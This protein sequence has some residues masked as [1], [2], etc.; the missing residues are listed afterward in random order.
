MGLKRTLILFAIPILVI[1][2]VFSSVRNIDENDELTD[3][4]YESYSKDIVVSELSNNSE[5]LNICDQWREYNWNMDIL[6]ELNQSHIKFYVF[7]QN[8][9]YTST[10]YLTESYP[11]NYYYFN[12]DY[13]ETPI[14]M[15]I[16][17][18]FKDTTVQRIDLYFPHPFP[19]T[20]DPEANLAGRLRHIDN[21]S[22]L[23]KNGKIISRSDV[24]NKARSLHADTK[25]FSAELFMCNGTYLKYPGLIYHNSSYLW[26]V[27]YD[28]FHINRQGIVQY[29]K[30][31]DLYNATDGSFAGGMISV[32][33]QKELE[34]PSA[35]SP[36]YILAFGLI[37]TFIIVY[38]VILMALRRKEVL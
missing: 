15:H 5:I 18:L 16:I 13:K 2:L 10:L 27:E 20:I 25:N 34:V 17:V 29:Y 38:A 4:D 28:I 12:Y 36:K 33:V 31:I 26:R 3:D 14:V 11:G 1:L 7:N 23:E 19:D 9:S 8:G 22:S 30:G 24:I 32:E 35:D 21:V 6:T 37:L